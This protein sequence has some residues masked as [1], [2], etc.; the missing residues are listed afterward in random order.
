MFVELSCFEVTAKGANFVPPT[1][2]PKVLPV[3]IGPN[4]S[5]VDVKV[6]GAD[7]PNRPGDGV[8]A[9][10]PKVDLND[11]PGTREEVPGPNNPLDA[12]GEEEP[13]VPADGAGV[14]KG[15]NDLTPEPKPPIV[16]PNT[17]VTGADAPKVLLDAEVPKVVGFPLPPNGT[18]WAPKASIVV[19]CLPKLEVDP[20]GVLELDVVMISS[21]RSGIVSLCHQRVRG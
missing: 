16:E 11:N 1:G 2:A 7:G 21:S 12:V 8:G 4:G 6:M 10:E 17:D 9:G 20:N 15:D 19:F 3:E 13:N 18:A 14:P 5:F